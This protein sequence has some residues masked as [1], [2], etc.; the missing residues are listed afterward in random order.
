[1]RHIIWKNDKFLT[2]LTT[3]KNAGNQAIHIGNNSQEAK[4]FRK[5]LAHDLQIEHTSFVYPH[6]T[7][8]DTILKITKCDCGVGFDSFESGVR[9]DALYTFDANV[10]LAIF[11][12]D[13]VPVF[14]YV[15]KKHLVM[16]IH[17]GEEG[18][19]K[20]IT[21][22]AIKY[23]IENEDVQPSDICAH[24]GPS[25]SLLNYPSN[26]QTIDRVVALGYECGAK[27]TNGIFFLDLPLINYAQLRKAGVSTKNISMSNLCTFERS[28]LFFSFNRDK[29]DEGRMLSLIR[30]N[31]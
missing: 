19:L 6:Q 8:S 14:I 1:M 25:R 18:T 26:K 20:E 29:K 16:V 23:I 15:Q 12:A 9:A 21:F 7:H 2:A 4:Q 22:K 5:E 24:I 13:C 31:S 28:D 3:T 17:A 11:H 27:S 10:T 30:L